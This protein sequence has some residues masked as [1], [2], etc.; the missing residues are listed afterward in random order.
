MLR[1]GISIAGSRV[2]QKTDILLLSSMNNTRSRYHIIEEPFSR[3]DEYSEVPIRFEVL[4]IFEVRGDD[5]SSA[6]LVEKPVADPWVKDFDTL[7]R[8][9]PMEWPKRRDTIGMRIP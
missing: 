3:L 8:G 7:Q 6:L 9:G 2:F 1:W 4:S 5:P